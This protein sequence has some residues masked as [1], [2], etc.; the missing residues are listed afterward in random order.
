M[1]TCSMAAISGKVAGETVDS[2]EKGDDRFKYSGLACLLYKL[3]KNKKNHQ[4]NQK[5]S[6]SRSKSFTWRTKANQRHRWMSCQQESHK[7]ATG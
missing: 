3:R 6:V 1:H 7:Q 4:F 5:W 2:E